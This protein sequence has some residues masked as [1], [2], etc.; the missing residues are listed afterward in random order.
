MTKNR[1]LKQRDKLPE[2]ARF[3]D[4]DGLKAFVEAEMLG[5]NPPQRPRTAALTLKK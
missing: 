2:W 1:K 5:A 3:V 4:L